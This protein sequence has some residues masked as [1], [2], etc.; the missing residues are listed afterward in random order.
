MDEGLI[1][2]RRS[3]IRTHSRSKK[4]TRGIFPAM[5]MP[6]VS[7]D[8]LPAA[9]YRASHEPRFR[10]SSISV[11]IACMAE[12]TLARENHRFSASLRR[13][14]GS[15]VP[16]SSSSA[17]RSP[18]RI[19]GSIVRISFISVGR[20]YKKVTFALP[21]APRFLAVAARRNQ[22]NDYEIPCID[23]RPVCLDPFPRQA[24]GRFGRQA[25][26]PACV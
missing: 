25:D 24:A 9:G 23:S 19:K 13:I 22:T 12:T 15:I 1:R 7:S 21:P 18:K 6:T 4:P 14:T 2:Q 5:T 10:P 3:Q 26:D 17:R 20:N 11:H 8:G 16:S